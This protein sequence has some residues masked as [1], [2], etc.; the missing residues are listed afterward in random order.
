PAIVQDARTHEVLTLAY[1]NA[2]SLKLTQESKETWFWSR[3]RS[4]LWRKG[5]TSGNTQR[6]IEIRRDC[7]SDALVVLVEPAG[8]ACHTGNRSCF[9]RDLAGAETDPHFR[10][11]PDDLGA[12]LDD[13][14]RLIENRKRE[15]PPDSYT[16]Y[17]FQE[18]LDKI[19]KKIGE[20][21]SE[22]IIAAKNEDKSA[23][24]SETADL[25]YHL[26]VL[27]V[28]RGVS[29]DEVR[30]ELVARHKEKSMA[31]E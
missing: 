31:R 15:L 17:L 11:Q 10:E 18:G 13:L 6:V 2:E 12:I 5:S 19:L 21:S 22:T 25:L 28:A 16:T 14:F 20:E 24:I 1:M 29:L 9:Y 27:L 26:M 4:E 30:D 23:L 3:S 8:P 7:D